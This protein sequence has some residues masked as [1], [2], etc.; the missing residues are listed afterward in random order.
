MIGQR[1]FRTASARRGTQRRI[2]RWLWWVP[3]VLAAGL[4]R[5]ED[6]PQWL[7]PRRDGVSREKG[8]G[9]GY[10]SVA[11]A[12]GRLYTLGNTNDTD[13]LL[14]LDAATGRLLWQHTYACSATAPR[15]LI[16]LYGGTRSTP[17]VAGGKVYSFSRDGQLF[18]LSAD[19]GKV[20][21]SVDVRKKPLGAE[22]PS[23]GF[24][25]SPLVT[26][27][28]VILDAGPILALD[29]ASGKCGWKSKSYRPAYSSPIALALTGRPCIATLNGEGLTVVADADGSEVLSYPF[30]FLW[31]E[32]CVTPIVSDGRCFISAGE[33]PGS[34]LVR[35]EKDKA[36]E[37][38]RGSNM[39]NLSTNSVLHE[40][41]LYGFHG[42]AVGAKSFR[43]VEFATGKRKWTTRSI[44]NG[45]LM[46]ADG[47]LI[48]MD[49]G[50]ELVIAPASPEALVPLTRK[51]VLTGTCWTV[52]VLANGRIYCRNAAGELVCLDV[53]GKK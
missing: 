15:T 44:R 6:W 12:K 53:Q 30:T 28:R 35:L 48:A 41:H 4:A 38:W 33:R 8:F 17:T 29:A 45:A 21:W 51:K 9:A 14:C 52:P 10:S 25:C 39:L 47:K 49:G 37:V 20:L 22:I 5:G 18:C 11:V 31:V 24:A 26:G 32:S 3:I 40:G 27:G 19:K 1:R 34:A 46:I 13:T 50:G 7:G 42:S 2:A 43:C 36:V 16:K 23:W